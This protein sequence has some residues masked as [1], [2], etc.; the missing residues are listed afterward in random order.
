M[1]MSHMK[2]IILKND[3]VK[4]PFGLII[5]DYSVSGTLLTFFSKSVAGFVSYCLVPPQIIST[6]QLAKYWPLPLLSGILQYVV[7]MWWQLPGEYG[8]M[9]M[10]SIYASVVSINVVSLPSSFGYDHL[11]AQLIKLLPKRMHLQLNLYSAHLG[12]L[13]DPQRPPICTAV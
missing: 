7:M 3:S 9:L 1:N 5:L 10:F 11:C 13:I 4:S 8:T 6:T 2:K 12:G